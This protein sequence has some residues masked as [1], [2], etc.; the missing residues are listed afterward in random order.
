[1]PLENPILSI[2]ERVT[3]LNSRYRNQKTEDVLRDILKDPLFGPV[4]L[5]S[6]FGAEAVVLLHMISV[7]DPATPVIFIDTEM[8]FPQ[9]LA[10]QKD[11]AEKFGLTDVRRIT[12]SREAVF[13]RDTDN[14][15]HLADRDS[16]CALRKTEPLERALIGFDAWIGGRKRFQ[17]G[18]RVAIEMFENEADTRI[19]INPLAHW[20]REDVADYI[21]VN[22]LPRHPLVAKGYLSIG[23]APC[24]T[25]VSAGEDYRAGRWRGEEKTECGIHLASHVP[26]SGEPEVNTAVIVNDEGFAPDDWDRGY[27]VFEDMDDLSETQKSALAIDLPNTFDATD[28][29]PW[30]DQIDLIRV[31]FPV[32]SDG[33]GFSLAQRLRLLGYHGRLRA[34][35]H[36]LADQYAMV[37]RSGFDEVEISHEL[38]NRQPQS[39]W[40]ARAA[41]Q[42]HNY[43]QKFYQST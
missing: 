28:L 35:G 30:I 3:E 43:Q 5:V 38:A 10:Y 12:P 2:S 18:V 4:A 6:S 8:L 40:S 37:R 11:L 21:T 14:L 9:T 15:L 33:R 34:K 19:K 32:F 1:M 39:Q 25:P 17:G 24:T 29:L 20:S 7:I 41:W 42:T 27:S 22:T 16:C 36:V 23:C 31:E 13:Q 26:N